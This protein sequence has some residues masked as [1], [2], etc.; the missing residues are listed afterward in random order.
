MKD[1]IAHVAAF[2]FGA[3]TGSLFFNYIM[4]PI[5]YKMFGG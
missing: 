5:F 1:K 2:I 4:Y 3:I